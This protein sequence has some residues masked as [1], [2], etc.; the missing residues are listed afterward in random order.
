MRLFIIWMKHERRWMMKASDYFQEQSERDE[1]KM[2]VEIFNGTIMQILDEKKKI[3]YQHKI[4][5]AI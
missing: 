5:F 2:F 3:L 1:V 4:M